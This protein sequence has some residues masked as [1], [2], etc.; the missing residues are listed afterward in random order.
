MVEAATL[1]THHKAPERY[2]NW[3]N[4]GVPVYCKGMGKL[5]VYCVGI[6]ELMSSHIFSASSA[7]RILKVLFV[8]PKRVS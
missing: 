2:E 8:L 6:L 5:G 3:V 7:S 1:V 4:V